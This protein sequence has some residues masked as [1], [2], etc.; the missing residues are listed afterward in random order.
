MDQTFNIFQWNARSVAVNLS[1]LQHLASC[2]YQVLVLQ[3]LN[4]TSNK[5]P[6]LPNYYYPPV[7]SKLDCKPQNEIYTAIYVHQGLQYLPCE[8][9]VPTHLPDIHSCAICVKV[10]DSL[11]LNVVSVYLPRG[12]NDQNTEW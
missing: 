5:L 8:S 7:Y 9:P 4:V 11:T 3:S 2:K 10:N 12:P 1:Y 6:K